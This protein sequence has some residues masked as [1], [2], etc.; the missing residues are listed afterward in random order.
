[1]VKKI[2]FQ[3]IFR[4]PLVIW[5]IVVI[6]PILWIFLGAFKQYGEIFRTPWALPESWNFGNFAAAWSDYNIGS[7][8]FNSLLVTG[9]GALLCLFF[10][11]PTAYAIVRIRFRGSQILFNIYL[12]SMMIP[13]VLAWIPLFFLLRDLNL[14]DNLFALALIYSVTQVP[15]TV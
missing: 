10:A 12:A 6:Y 9:L 1:M 13:M 15:F 4:I 11:L 8:F 14:I 5:A 7:S 3:T 2:L